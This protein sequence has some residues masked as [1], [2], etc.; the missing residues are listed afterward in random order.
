MR[1]KT[2]KQKH[3]QP[4]VS[5]FFKSDPK[6]S[7]SDKKKLIN[8]SV[9]DISKDLRPF[10]AIE[11]PGFKNVAECLVGLGA[12]YGKFDITKA[13][14]SRN[15]VKRHAVDQADDLQK[16]IIGLMASAIAENGYVGI[17]TD[18]WTDGNNR[19]YLSMTLHFCKSECFHYCVITVDQF[20]EELK[21]GKILESLLSNFLRKELSKKSY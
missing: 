14:P 1:K 5:S 7:Q 11:D 12:K 21:S 6:L 2:N 19:A 10:K 15:T 16:K 17:T 13:L 20:V 8:A 18:M 4:S 9:Q 3:Q